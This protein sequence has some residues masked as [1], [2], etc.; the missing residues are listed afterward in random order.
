MEAVLAVRTPEVSLRTRT[1]GICSAG[2]LP[3][4]LLE[5]GDTGVAT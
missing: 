4:D 3:G 1:Q 2:A 5:V